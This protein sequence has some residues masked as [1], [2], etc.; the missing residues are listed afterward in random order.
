MEHALCFTRCSFLV[1]A[2]VA[3]CVSPR[4]GDQE[5]GA[6]GHG[7]GARPRGAF[8][9]FLRKGTR[10]GMTVLARDASDVCA[11]AAVDGPGPCSRVPFVFCRLLLACSCVLLSSLSGEHVGS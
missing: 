11:A 1:T 5:G 10:V 6:V 4:R 3:V 9:V 2:D 8:R 7:R